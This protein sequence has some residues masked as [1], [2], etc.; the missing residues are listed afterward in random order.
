[1]VGTTVD[2]PNKTLETRQGG[3]MKRTKQ[4]FKQDMEKGIELLRQIKALAV[5]L[6]NLDV[7]PVTENIIDSVE[8]EIDYLEEFDVEE[9]SEL[10]DE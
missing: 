9:I 6:Q 4:Q 2:N 8:E 1:M 3:N 7:T 5:E 10:F